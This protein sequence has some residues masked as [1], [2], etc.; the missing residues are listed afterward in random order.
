MNQV[1][2]KAMRILQFSY[3]EYWRLHKEYSARHLMRHLG[4]MEALLIVPGVL[5]E[6]EGTGDHAQDV[7]YQEKYL[8]WES[9]PK[10]RK[11]YYYE[12]I[13]RLALQCLTENKATL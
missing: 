10:H 13:E 3:Y 7:T 4:A 8:F 1:S 6:H 12:V 11:E 5:E 2:P 9:A